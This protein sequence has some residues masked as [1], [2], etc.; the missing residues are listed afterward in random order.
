MGDK[1]SSDLSDF[2]FCKKK[3]AE[4]EAEEQRR[5][6]AIGEATKEQEKEIREADGLTDFEKQER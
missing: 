1:R 6:E 4:R 3:N 2:G 5:R